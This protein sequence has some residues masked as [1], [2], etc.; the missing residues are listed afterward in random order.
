MNSGPGLRS[1]QTPC[2]RPFCFLVNVPRFAFSGL[3]W[4]ALHCIT[5]LT[6]SRLGLSSRT[7]VRTNISGEAFCFTSIWFLLPAAAPC[8][9]VRVSFTAFSFCL[10]ITKHVGCRELPLCFDCRIESPVKTWWFLYDWW[11]RNTCDTWLSD[12]FSLSLSFSSPNLT[13]FF[14][15]SVF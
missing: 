13:S 11:Q 5:S 9:L 2:C 15:V 3:D 7:V 10:I 14:S 6:G 4:I 12:V 1:G 8:N